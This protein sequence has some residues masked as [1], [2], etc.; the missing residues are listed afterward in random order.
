MSSLAKIAIYLYQFEETIAT[1]PQ[2]FHLPEND[3]TILQQE[4]KF[5]PVQIM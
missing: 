3:D 4:D 2:K 5:D 1:E